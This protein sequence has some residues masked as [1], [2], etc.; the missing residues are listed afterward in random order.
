LATG[1]KLEPVLGIWRFSFKY[2]EI[3]RIRVKNFPQKSFL[4][5]KI[6][7]FSLKKCEKFG[8]PKK[9]TQ[10]MVAMFLFVQF[11]DVGK[12]AMI[13]SKI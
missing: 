4:C 9:K 8:L 2:F 1:W 10:S 7:F 13:H 6:I 5:L 11:C 12:M 3:W